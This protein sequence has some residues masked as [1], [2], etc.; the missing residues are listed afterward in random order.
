MRVGIFTFS[1]DRDMSP[2]RL[3][4]EVEARGFTRLMFT[5]HSHIPV[6]RATPYPDVYGGGVLPDFY[7]RTYD[8]FVA[9]SFAAAAT[10]KIEV[11]TSVC[12]LALRDPIHTAK[13]IASVDRLSDGRFVFGVGFGWNADEFVSHRA[14]FNDRHATV[15]ERVA[16]MR[17]LWTEDE[18]SYS[19]QHA[20]LEPS[21]AW[22]KPV[23]SPHPPVLVGGNGPRAMGHAARWGNGWYPT[24]FA[25]YPSV[26]AAVAQYHELTEKAGRD[27][28]IVSV[29]VAAAG[30]TEA[31]L[32]EFR[33]AG[34]DRV[35]IIALA[36]S[37]DELLSQ[38]DEHA[39]LRD[40]VQ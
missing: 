22:P 19:G 24:T 16:V 29:G 34:L 13:E 21:W 17:A 23:T 3:G 32:A 10:S 39:R 28:Q 14:S 27:P 37:D 7:Q 36:G 38:L 31:Q 18:A 9:C 20:Q 11:G 6:S 25:G 5:E 33:D 26:A 4:R 1:T 30:V 15:E 2:A 12:L 8:P 35:D 40:S